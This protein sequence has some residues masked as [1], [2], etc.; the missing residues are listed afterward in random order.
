MERSGVEW[1]EVEE[2]CGSALIDRVHLHMYCTCIPLFLPSPTA[3]PRQIQTPT[4]AQKH[5]E[6]TR[7]YS[8]LLLPDLNLNRR[9]VGIGVPTP[10]SSSPTRLNSNFLPTPLI[11]L[12]FSGSRRWAER[13]ERYSSP[14]RG[15]PHPHSHVECGVWS[16]GAIRL[17]SFAACTYRTVRTRRGGCPQDKTTQL[18]DDL[19]GRCAC[20]LFVF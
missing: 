1:K 7:L 6:V 12:R 19:N 10:P 15:D 9:G 14:G 8:A 11:G 20:S 2:R 4:K 17:P 5:H 3:R 13:H 18:K 16:V